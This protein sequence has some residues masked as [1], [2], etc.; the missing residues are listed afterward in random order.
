MKTKVIFILL[1]V[2]LG[3]GLVWVLG[4]G[5]PVAHAQG[6]DGTST[7]YVAPS[8]AGTLAPCYTTVQDAV[9]AA[10]DPGDVI[11]VATGVYTGVSARPAPAG[12]PG[13]PAGGLITQ[14][15]Y[16]T[17]TVTIQ[18]GYAATFT[19]PP[20]P[21]ANP[22]TLDAQGQGRVLFIAGAISPTIE[23]LHITGGDAVGLGG[24]WEGTTAYDAGGGVYVITATATIRDNRVFNNTITGWSD[25]GGICLVSSDATVSGNTITNN[26]AHWGGGLSVDHRGDAT[27][28]GNTITNNTANAD[29]GGMQL[30]HSDATV[31]GNTFSANR[32]TATAAGAGFGGGLFLWYSNA[33]TVSGN[34]FSANTATKAGGGLH[35]DHSDA[36][37]VSGNTFSVNT[38]DQHGGGLNLTDSDAT[39]TNNIVADNQANI[40]GSGISIWSSS[41]RLLHNT[42]A[43]NTGGGGR[44]IYVTNNSDVEM[45]NTVLVGHSVGIYVA[46]G[47]RADLE[48]TL[49]GSGTWANTTDRS[50]PGTINHSEDHTGDPAFVNPAAGDYHIGLGSAALDAGADAGVSTDIDGDPRPIGPGYDLGADEW[51]GSGLQVTKRATPDPVQPGA[52][53]TYTIGITNATGVEVHAT[54]TDTLPLSVTLDEAS[55]GTSGMPGGTLVPPDGTVVLPDGR[56]AVTW[57]AVITR[58]GGLWRGMILVTVDEDCVGSLA[59]LVEVTTEEGAMGADSVTVR[60][61]WTVYLPI[62]LR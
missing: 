34:T 33:A 24:T 57:T 36:T 7:Y 45:V 47:S 31:S 41:P 40:A 18:G 60:A 37:T 54:I 2:G 53:L 20:D 46:A 13:A 28:S 49:W 59:N 9:D 32:A 51:P 17:K 43:R 22:T 15:V 5:F 12:Y 56:V 38:A 8:C 25:G 58:L 39:L 26:S 11:K 14:V 1:A 23:G 50:G 21:V 44:G 6:P 10:D 27:V 30:A 4:S 29:G 19:D 3:L 62:V 35:L 48:T 52:Q 16:V 42:I 55:G 61:G